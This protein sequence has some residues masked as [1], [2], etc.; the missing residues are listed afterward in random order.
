[1]QTGWSERE[2]RQR[3]SDVEEIGVPTAGVL[4][5]AGKCTDAFRD[6]VLTDTRFATFAGSVTIA[7]VDTDKVEYLVRDAIVDYVSPSIAERYGVPRVTLVFVRSVF[8]QHWEVFVLWVEEETLH[9]WV[10]TATGKELQERFGLTAEQLLEI[11]TCFV[12]DLIRTNGING[13]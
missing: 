8:D 9:G 5:F 4:K 12:R 7:V 6:K 3:V 2:R 10:R 1:M 11:V 13:L